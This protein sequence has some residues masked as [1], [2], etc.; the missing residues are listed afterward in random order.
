MPLPA[1]IEDKDARNFHSTLSS[2]FEV[3]FS[4]VKTEHSWSL[5][6]IAAAPETLEEYTCAFQEQLAHFGVRDQAWKIE[7]IKETD[8]LKK[9]YTAPAP[10][11]T[12]P[13]FIHHS[14]YEGRIPEDALSLCIDAVDAFGDGHHPTTQGCL[15]ALDYLDVQGV[16]PWNILDIGT[17][18]GLLSIA[19]WK[20]WK[21]PVLAI[22]NDPR[23]LKRCAKH[24]ETN[25]IPGKTGGVSCFL[26]RSLCDAA[27]LNKGPYELVMA[28]IPAGTLEN[29]MPDINILMDE[30]AFI[31]ISGFL[32]EKEDHMKEIFAQKFHFIRSFSAESWA[33]LL[34][35]K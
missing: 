31:V 18:S 7:N 22:D 24:L 9:S 5:E 2:L 34:F 14:T 16:C 15:H 17:G 3:P 28:N 4:L 13:F 35:S 29:M 19:A 1:L 20:L 6:V 25:T 21:A 32:M 23:A 8:W 12:G 33:T 26:S 11:R 27:I 10:L 30:N